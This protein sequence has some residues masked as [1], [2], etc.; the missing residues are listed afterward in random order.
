MCMSMSAQVGWLAVRSAICYQ[1]SRVCVY[2]FQPPTQNKHTHMHKEGGY[3]DL[4]M[5][6]RADGVSVREKSD[7]HNMR[8]R[9]HISCARTHT[10]THARAHTSKHADGISVVERLVHMC[11]CARTHMHLDA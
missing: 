10:H 7:T 1:V 8:A 9:T 5:Q 6:M 4:G 11:V 2:I 3:L